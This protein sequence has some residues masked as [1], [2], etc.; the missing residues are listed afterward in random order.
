MSHSPGLGPVR[1][2]RT[3]PVFL[4]GPEFLPEMKERRTRTLT[5]KP[6]DNATGCGPASP[7]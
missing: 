2:F 6:I 5:L 3:C 1:P 7:R 4:T